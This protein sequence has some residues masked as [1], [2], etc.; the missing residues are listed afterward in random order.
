MSSYNYGSSSSTYIGESSSSHSYDY[1]GSSSSTSSSK[2]YSYS[3][4]DVNSFK[5]AKKSFERT[6]KD[7]K[8]SQK[9]HEYLRQKRAE[10]A[11]LQKKLENAQEAAQ[12]GKTSAEKKLEEFKMREQRRAARKGRGRLGTVLTSLS[13]EGAA[14]I[15]RRTLLG[16]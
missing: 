14:D 6:K 15:Q 13:G 10:G 8:Q 4:P 9:V 1:G 16:G 11:I 12:E 3:P 7:W 2:G 5:Q